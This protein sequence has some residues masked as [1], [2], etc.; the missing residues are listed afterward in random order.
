MNIYLLTRTDRVGCDE[1]D[2]AV[3]VAASPEDAEK[4]RPGAISGTEEYWNNL[5][6]ELVGVAAEGLKAGDVVLASFNAG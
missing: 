4:V 1:Y 3:V 2:A 5:K 6:C